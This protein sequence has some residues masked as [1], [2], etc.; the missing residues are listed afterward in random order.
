MILKIKDV[1]VEIDNF[2][3]S[4]FDETERVLK[5]SL[6]NKAIKNRDAIKQAFKK[7]VESSSNANPSDL[8]HH[9]VYRIYMD[10]LSQFRRVSDSMQS[11]KRASGDAFE[12]FLQDYYN[13][14]LINH[15]IQVVTFTNKKDP[16]EALKMMGIY[17][18]VGDSKLDIALMHNCNPSFSP[19]LKNGKILGGI[20]AKASLAERVS[21]DEPASRAMINA[22]FVSFLAT[23]DVKSFPPSETVTDERAYINKGELG[24]PSNPTDKRKYIEE[25]GSFDACFSYNLRTVPSPEKTT[26]G[27][28]IYTEKMDGNWDSF[29]DEIL[30]ASQERS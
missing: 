20:H 28:K 8:W 29:C 15:G 14:L 7:A 22:G 23:L 17:G 3:Q 21:D 30:K 26:S 27:K 18:Q 16:V 2:T 5:T 6:Q 13:P 9:V 24:S 12:I 1:D 19:S 11:W 4:N 10:N 25:H